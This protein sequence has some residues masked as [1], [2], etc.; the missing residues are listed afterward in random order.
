LR[1]RSVPATSAEG[2]WVGTVE[3]QLSEDDVALA[4]FHPK[5]QEKFYSIKFDVWEQPIVLPAT[6]V[7]VL[8]NEA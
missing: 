1:A 8:P 7:I 2:G 3:S 5:Q 4:G 6:L